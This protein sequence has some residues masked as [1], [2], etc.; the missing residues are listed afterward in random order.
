MSAAQPMPNAGNVGAEENNN[1]NATGA[2]A[3]EEQTVPK[4]PKEVNWAPAG[5]YFVKAVGLQQ[6][7]ISKN[8]LMAFLISSISAR[9]QS[10][11]E[12][13][14]LSLLLTTDRPVTR[15][16][17]WS[18]KWLGR[19]YLQPM[20]LADSLEPHFSFCTGHDRH[21]WDKD[22]Y[23]SVHFCWEVE[24]MEHSG[25]GLF[26]VHGHRF[27][28]QGKGVQLILPVFFTFTVLEC[29]IHKIICF[30]SQ[31]NKGNESDSSSS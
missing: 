22:S 27:H 11:S 3:K 31:F 23:P 9:T 20:V 19:T 6:W 5:Y 28:L 25:R 1:E 4:K 7:F 26:I 13:R 2:K 17:M 29:N 18:E 15:L 10:Q 24:I 30:V 14:Q 16:Y 12:R 8:L 21:P